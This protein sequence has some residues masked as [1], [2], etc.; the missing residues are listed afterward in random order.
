M[1]V[2]VGTGIHVVY[3]MACDFPRLI[4]ASSDR[5]A[6]LE[7]YFKEQPRTGNWLREWKE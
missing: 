1:G 6:L 7:P 3:H 2:A 4:H 5:F